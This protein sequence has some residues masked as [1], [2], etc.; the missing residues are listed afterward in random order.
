MVVDTRNHRGVDLGDGE[1]LGGSGSGLQVVNTREAPLEAGEDLGEDEGEVVDTRE[2][3][4]Q[5]GVSGG[6]DTGE[7]LLQAGII[8]SGFRHNLQI[9]RSVDLTSLQIVAVGRCLPR[10][11]KPLAKAHLRNDRHVEEVL[12][13]RT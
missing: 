12:Y 7:A 6:V 2:V 8:V 1:A 5:A 13:F 11:C 9:V 3:L 4:L 10:L